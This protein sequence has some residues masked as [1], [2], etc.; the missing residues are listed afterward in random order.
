[1]NTTIST[2][3]SMTCTPRRSRRRALVSL[4]AILTSALAVTLASSGPAG[5]A[6]PGSNGKI[7]FAGYSAGDYN[8]WVMNSDGS[9]RTYLTS[10]TDWET[11]PAFSP[12]GSKIAYT[13]GETTGAN[14]I[15][16][17]NANGA[18]QTNLTPGN[19]Q[20]DNAAWS[21]DGSKIAYESHR[22]GNWEVWVMNADGSGQTN[23]TQHPGEDGEPSWSPDGSKIAFS[24]YRD[25]NNEIYVM[26]ADGSGQTN[27]TQNPAIEFGPDWSPDGSKIAYGTGHPHQIHVMNADGSGQT[28]LSQNSYT[29][30]GPS[31]SPD[32]S[33]IA[34]TSWRDGNGEI[35]VMNADG[36][37]QNNLTQLVDEDA[38]PSWQTLPSSDL[39]LSL[40]TS[41]DEAKVQKPLAYTVRVDN[42]GP[43]NAAGLVVTNTLPAEARFVSVS[44]SQGSCVG[45][46]AG[47]TGTVTCDL[48]FLLRSQATTAEVVIKVVAPRR[49]SITNVA[50]VASATPDPDT[51]NNSATIT[52]SVK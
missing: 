37:A 14:D 39:A 25:S 43:S 15:W 18:G 6:Y 44:S 23:L 34:F 19:G 28:N 20:D 35:Y 17:M 24:T 30:Q 29:D 49:S 5:A 13:R 41:S 45:P 2:P 3:S 27:L 26:N 12:D 46:P 32:G 48:G 16:V 52:T 36:S 42:S 9:N 40:T 21:P 33:K 8:I 22:S 11:D 1:M 50:S 4:L 10:S 7:A 38:G 47:S 51:A 31:W